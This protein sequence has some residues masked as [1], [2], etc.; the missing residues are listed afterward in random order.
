M[1]LETICADRASIKPLLTS[2]EIDDE[3]TEIEDSSHF[4]T[5]NVESEVEESFYENDDEMMLCEILSKFARLKETR[6]NN[7]DN[8]SK[9]D[10]IG[11]LISADK[12]RTDLA[13]N[14]NLGILN[15]KKRLSV[16]KLKRSA[17]ETNDEKIVNCDNDL[18]EI[19]SSTSTSICTP[20]KTQNYHFNRRPK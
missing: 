20:K 7:D 19:D 10:G 4:S 18:I 6:I 14:E 12:S 5:N 8:V 13:L 2:D 9:Q 16:S 3:A 1:D 15:H 17:L 11:L